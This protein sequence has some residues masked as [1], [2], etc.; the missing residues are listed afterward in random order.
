M[1]VEVIVGKGLTQQDFKQ[2]LEVSTV[3]H[4]P[5]KHSFGGN[6]LSSSEKGYP[7][8]HSKINVT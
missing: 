1:K 7:R 6:D 3:L 4:G 2:L 8:E 5:S